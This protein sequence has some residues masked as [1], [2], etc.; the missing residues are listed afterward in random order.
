MKREPMKKINPNADQG[1]S[2]GR[3]SVGDDAAN[4]TLE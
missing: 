1:E 4:V 3:Y 2:F